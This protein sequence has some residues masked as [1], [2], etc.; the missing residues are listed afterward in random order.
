MLPS[1]C[2]LLHER[3]L[4]SPINTTNPQQQPKHHQKNNPKLKS[5]QSHTTLPHVVAP[6]RKFAHFSRLTA[7]FSEDEQRE[8]F[9]KNKKSTA[10]K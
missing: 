7:D 6:A 3:K 10:D 5:H 8:I 2:A 9:S 4:Q 1:C